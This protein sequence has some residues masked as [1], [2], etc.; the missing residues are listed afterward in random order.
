MRQWGTLGSADGQLRFPTHIDFDAAGSLYVADSNNHRIQVFSADGVFQRKFG[1][2]GTAPG[3][4]RFPVG[5][6]IG[7]DGFV[8]VTDT[9]NNR[10]PVSYTHLH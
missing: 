3:Q 10:V 1:V 9:F 5:I 2:T 6:D 8:Y 7:A 4:F